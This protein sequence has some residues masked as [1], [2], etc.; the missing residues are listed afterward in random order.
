VEVPVEMPMS[1][2]STFPGSKILSPGIPDVFIRRV[3]KAHVL[4]LAIFLA[5]CPGI[6]PISCR[7]GWMEIM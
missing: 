3:L 1:I 7:D 6:S 5:G 2:G 4:L